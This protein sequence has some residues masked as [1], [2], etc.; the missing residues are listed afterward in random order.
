MLMTAPPGDVAPKSGGCGEVIWNR[1]LAVC[2]RVRGWNPK[3]DQN[4]IRKFVVLISHRG[5]DHIITGRVPCP[6]LQRA[7]CRST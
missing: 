3:L 7:R 1:S 6:W 5:G 2:P 4:G